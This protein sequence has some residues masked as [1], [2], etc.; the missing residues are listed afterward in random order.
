MDALYNDDFVLTGNGKSGGGKKKNSNAA[1]KEKDKSGNYI[2]S[3]KHVRK[4][5]SRILRSNKKEKK[6]HKRK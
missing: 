4:M 5:E 6:E 3:S 2:Y 1:Q